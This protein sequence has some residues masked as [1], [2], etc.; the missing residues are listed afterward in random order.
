MELQWYTDHCITSEL[1]Y[2]FQFSRVFRGG[3]EHSLRFNVHRT[4]EGKQKTATS[5]AELVLNSQAQGPRPKH[6]T[7]SQCS[8]LVGAPAWCS[9]Q[10]A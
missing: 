5:T 1:V 10:L 3:L 2:S 8:A 6:L 7:T 9:T 4:Q